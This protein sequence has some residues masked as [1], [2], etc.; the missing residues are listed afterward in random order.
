MRHAPDDL[1]CISCFPSSMFCSKTFAKQG[2]LIH[3]HYFITCRCCCSW[4]KYWVSSSADAEWSDGVGWYW[5]VLVATL[6]S[7]NPSLD[8]WKASFACWKDQRWCTVQQPLLWSSLFRLCRSL[9][10]RRKVENIRLSI[11]SMP[12]WPAYQVGHRLMCSR[13]PHRFDRN[14]FQSVCSYRFETV[15]MVDYARG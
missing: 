4:C 14:V 6:L 12:T 13:Y 15:P 3:D 10:V 11:F 2:M 9:S 7:C 5:K 1:R 8:Q